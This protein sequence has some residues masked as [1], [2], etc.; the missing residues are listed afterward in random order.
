MA[1]LGVPQSALRL[2]SCQPKLGMSAF[3]CSLSPSDRVPLA[4]LKLARGT[5]EPRCTEK[6]FWKPFDQLSRSSHH[7]P[8]APA[9]T[10]PPTPARPR[11][12]PKSTASPTSA[13]WKRACSRP[14]FEELPHPRRPAVLLHHVRVQRGQ[15]TCQNVPGVMSPPAS[16]PESQSSPKPCLSG[17][18][19]PAP[20]AAWEKATSPGQGPVRGIHWVETS[21]KK[22]PRTIMV[23]DDKEGGWK[24]GRKG[25]VGRTRETANRIRP[26]YSI[27]SKTGFFG[28]EDIRHTC[29]CPTGM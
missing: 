17:I 11:R 25:W 16:V 4:W 29:P 14:G 5:K 22:T 19:S 20:R 27:S 3:T 12:P 24:V 15:A 26:P 7:P 18:S 23:R 2:L 8:S 21:T 9:G 1:E 6:R 13:G 10:S 28:A